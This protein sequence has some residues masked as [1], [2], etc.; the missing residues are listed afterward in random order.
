MP[1][2]DRSMV[3]TTAGGRHTSARSRGRASPAITCTHLLGPLRKRS[4][5]PIGDLRREARPQVPPVNRGLRRSD[6]VAADNPA[7]EGSPPAVGRRY[8][9]SSASE[10]LMWARHGA[11]CLARRR[12]TSRW[13]RYSFFSRRN[14][15]TGSST[16]SLV[17]S[18]GPP[19][20][21]TAGRVRAAPAARPTS[22]AASPPGWRP[23][24]AVQTGRSW[25]DSWLLSYSS[26]GPRVR[27]IERTIALGTGSGLPWAAARMA[28]KSSSRGASFSR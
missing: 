11:K 26:A 25:F 2:T 23:S 15:A 21:R 18:V 3:R 24:F 9:Q 7:H 17:P 19:A 27:S 20:R 14:G 6:A 5:Q 28:S 16:T 4:S 10:R 1:S 22:G 13:V 8:L 12:A